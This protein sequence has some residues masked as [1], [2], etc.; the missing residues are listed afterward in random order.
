MT[1]ALP[2]KTQLYRHFDANGRLLYVG[3]SA[4]AVY[5]FLVHKQA[6]CWAD[7]ITTITIETFPSRNEAMEAERLA[8]KAKA[9]LYNVSPRGG[10]FKPGVRASEPSRIGES[11]SRQI[12][13]GRILAELSQS[14]VARL[15]GLS[16]PTVRRVESERNVH[17][18]DAARKAV[19]GALKAR[20]VIF[21][22]GKNP[23][24]RVKPDSP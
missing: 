14:D 20:G 4:A 18:S 21:I 6:S 1:G 16:I 3:V 22:G 2:V 7:Q 9:P 24:V 12:K 10:G 8:I 23:G 17:V 11:S 19:I 15:A 5:R 13:A